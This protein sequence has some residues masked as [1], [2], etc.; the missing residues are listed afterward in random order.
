MCFFRLYEANGRPVFLQ[1]IELI[2]YAANKKT[3]SLSAVYWIVCPVIYK[4]AET[5]TLDNTLVNYSVLISHNPRDKK[6]TK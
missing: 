1:A 2:F 5:Q 3:V 4:Y 6:S